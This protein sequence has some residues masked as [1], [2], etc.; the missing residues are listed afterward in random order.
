VSWFHVDRN[1]IEANDRDGGG[2]PILIRQNPDG[3]QTAGH[4][5]A[6]PGWM[7]TSQQATPNPA[8]PH[9]WLEVDD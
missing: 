7:L 4:L 8:R 3:S 2:R 1:A 9:A 6:G 5:F